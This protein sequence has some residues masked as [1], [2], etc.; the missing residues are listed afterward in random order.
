MD[1][2]AGTLAAIGSLANTHFGEAVK[3]TAIRI[4]YNAISP[5]AAFFVFPA[6]INR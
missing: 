4:F 1:S 3:L 5:M 6:G 2:S